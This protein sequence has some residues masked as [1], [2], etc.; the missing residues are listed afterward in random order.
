MSEIEKKLENIKSKGLLFHE[1]IEKNCRLTSY[2]Y[3]PKEKKIAFALTSG[4]GLN[5]EKHLIEFSEYDLDLKLALFTTKKGNTSEI[6][7]IK[8]K[9]TLQMSDSTQDNFTGMRKHLFEAIRK[10]EGGTMKS[11]DAKAMASLAQTIINSAKIEMEFKLLVNKS[12]D[13]KM[14]N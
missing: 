9:N 7:L 12:P 13:I 5:D 14:I 1:G 3:Y 8:P 2:S 6:E 10:L 11:E 4:Y